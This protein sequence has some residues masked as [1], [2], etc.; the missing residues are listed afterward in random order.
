MD[1]P[2]DQQ[3]IINILGI[4]SLPDDRKSE[5]VDKM[6]ELVQKRLLVK[7]LDSLTQSQRDEF[8]QI[9]NENDDDKFNEFVSKNIPQMAQWL[10]EEVNQLKQEL[11]ELKSKEA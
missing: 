7:V 5:L 4:Q 11:T 10:N 8:E 2:L 6:S 3:N 1:L 9:L